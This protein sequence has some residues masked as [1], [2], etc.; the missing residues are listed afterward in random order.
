MSEDLEVPAETLI[1]AAQGITATISKLSEI[2]VKE[3]AASGRGFSA[4][5]LSPLEAG[6][7]VVQ[8]GF[9]EFT[10]R[11]SWGVRNLVQ[12]GN[13]IAETLGLAAGRYNMMEQATKDTLKQIYTNLVG[14]PH[15]SSDDIKKRTLGQTLAD[16]P[17]NQVL[18]SDYSAQSFR[19]AQAQIA[20]NN[21][22]IQTV[23]PQALAN[24]GAASQFLGGPKLP[25]S[26][27][28]DAAWNTQGAEQAAAI[29]NPQQS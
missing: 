16:N 10:D 1:Q 7:E 21:Q 15:L 4:L 6:K 5:A 14:N 3:A 20:K 25:T 17:F 18:N 12:A 9:E 19:D 22:V 11:W 28:P 2:G 13:S 29:L 24:V 26:G 8:K 23:G 27:L